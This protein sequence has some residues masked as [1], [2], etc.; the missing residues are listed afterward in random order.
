LIPN[1]GLKNIYNQ[2]K[3]ITGLIT[4]VEFIVPSYYHPVR[5]KNKFYLE[6]IKI[7]GWGIRSHH[8]IVNLI[9]DQQFP[10][11]IVK[12]CSFLVDETEN[13]SNGALHEV[14]A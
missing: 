12:F 5:A 7:S 4:C 13:P 3:T 2:L 6:S 10:H 14:S 9:P 11:G 1:S 8:N